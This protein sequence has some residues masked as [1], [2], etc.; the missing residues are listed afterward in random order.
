M[1]NFLWATC[2][3]GFEAWLKNEVALRHPGLRSAYSRPGFLTFKSET[4]VAPEF[5]LRCAFARSFA[6][7]LGKLTVPSEHDPAFLEKLD[8]LAK[9]HHAEIAQPLSEPQ[10]GQ[11]VLC[12]TIARE[13]DAGKECWFGLHTHD[14]AVHRPWLDGIPSHIALPP[15]APSR[16]FLKM[17]EGLQWSRLALRAGDAALELGS[18]PGGAS[19]ALLNR[20]LRVSGVDP[21]DMADSIKTSPHFRHIR[22]QST[23]LTK[24]ELESLGS[25]Y[26]IFSD[27]NIDPRSALKSILSCRA[28]AP[29]LGG[30]FM[31]KL[32]DSIALEDMDSILQKLRAAGFGEVSMAQLYFNRAELCVAFG[33]R[34]L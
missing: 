19:L 29:A 2:Q 25:R 18:A 20:G 28:K 34:A 6:C 5:D 33:P 27:M 15:E 32:T 31:L 17:E 16:T 13:S 23:Q 11:R 14:P 22:K 7:S 9:R 26:W 3:T 24:T 4:P 30:L 12:H 21:A 8:E 10:K 1:T